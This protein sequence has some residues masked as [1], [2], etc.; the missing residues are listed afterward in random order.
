MDED[1]PTEDDLSPPVDWEQGDMTIEEYTSFIQGTFLSYHKEDQ[2]F[3]MQ[4]CGFWPWSLEQWLVSGMRQD[5]TSELMDVL[6]HRE[7]EI[8]G[9]PDMFD[10][11]W[12]ELVDAAQD[13]ED[14]ITLRRNSDVA[15]F[16]PVFD[17]GY[18]NKGFTVNNQGFVIVHTDGA[19]R[20]NGTANAKGGIGV[21]FGH[22]H[23]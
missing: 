5:I 7:D 3:W 19:C 12:D 2:D 8:M 14:M 6:E 15:S 18:K 13:A 1:S 16:K 10:M 20:G 11:P 23:V 21:W 22:N 17:L 4:Y 9:S